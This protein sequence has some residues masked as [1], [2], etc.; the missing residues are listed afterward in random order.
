[1]PNTTTVSDTTITFRAYDGDTTTATH[2]IPLGQ[3]RPL[4]ELI[5]FDPT[6]FGMD[7]HLSGADMAARA[8]QV[9]NALRLFCRDLPETEKHLSDLIEMGV[10]AE[11]AGHQITWGR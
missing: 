7:I 8:R 9:L 2:R 6:D 11:R 3:A 1:M 4:L 5:G 10:A